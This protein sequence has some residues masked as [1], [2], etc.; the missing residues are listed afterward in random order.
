MPLIISDDVRVSMPTDTGAPAVFIFPP[1]DDDKMRAAVRRLLDDRY[2]QRGKK[3]QNKA[4][5]ARRVFFD[6]T[7]TGC[8][9]VEYK[10]KPI[11]EALPDSWK[12][13]IPDNIVSSIV[14]AEFEERETLSDDEREDLDEAS[15]SA[16]S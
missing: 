9:G 14:S 2:K 1:Y 8:E 4:V 3:V 11:Q 5:Q 12:T 6:Q 7:C 13:K 16:E 10:G 15:D